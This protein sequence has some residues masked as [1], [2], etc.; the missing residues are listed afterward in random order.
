MRTTSRGGS[1][2]AVAMAVAVSATVDGAEDC[3]VATVVDADNVRGHRR[4]LMMTSVCCGHGNGMR[5]GEVIAAVCPAR[6]VADI[7]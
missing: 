7:M 4:W 1:A 3:A 5:N 2:R 6:P